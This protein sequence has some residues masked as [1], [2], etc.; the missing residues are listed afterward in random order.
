MPLNYCAG[1][2]LL[3][4]TFAITVLD[5]TLVLLKSAKTTYDVTLSQRKMRKKETTY[6]S[7]V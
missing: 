6:P 2:I 7:Y 1:V 5:N 3:K 4:F